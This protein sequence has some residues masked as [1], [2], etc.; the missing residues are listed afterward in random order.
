[1]YRKK[2]FYCC[3]GSKKYYED[4]YV[5]QAGG[6][7]PYFAGARIQR[8]HGLGSIL[9]GLFRS[10]LPLLKRGAMALGRQALSTGAQM[11]GDV[12]GGES[13]KASAKRRLKSAGSELLQKAAAHLQ[14]GEGIKRRRRRK[15][16][17]LL[18]TSGASRAKR[19]KKT[20]SSTR[21]HDIFD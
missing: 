7:L 20:K 1:M 10:A 17:V 12:L 8:G 2:G 19:S 5:N 6:G 11:A 9:S 3:D 21:R 15:G 16:A 4:Y 18:E 13:L 14:Q